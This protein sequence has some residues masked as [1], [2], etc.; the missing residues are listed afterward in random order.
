MYNDM[1]YQCS[2]AKTLLNICNTC[3]CIT[4]IISSNAP[5][6]VLKLYTS[7]TCVPILTIGY[8]T[9]YIIVMNITNY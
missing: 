8:N 3:N 5:S 6:I 4:F 2:N 1:Q 9:Y 7:N